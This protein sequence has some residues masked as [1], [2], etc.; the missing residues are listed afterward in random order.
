VINSATLLA[1][2]RPDSSH[3]QNNQID[4]R[5]RKILAAKIPKAGL[6]S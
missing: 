3:L 5:P 2:G 1:V 6:A 4:A